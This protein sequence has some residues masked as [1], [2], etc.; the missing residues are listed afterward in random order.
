MDVVKGPLEFS[1]SPPRPDVPP[2]SSTFG[3][4]Q[5]PP[6]R[7]MSH[8]TGSSPVQRSAGS[9]GR[10]ARLDEHFEEKHNLIRGRGGALTPVRPKRRPSLS[11]VLAHSERLNSSTPQASF[12]TPTAAGK[13]LGLPQL[14]RG[15]V[16]VRPPPAG[17]KLARLH[18]SG[19]T[20]RKPIPLPFLF[21]DADEMVEAEQVEQSQA[22]ARHCESQGSDLDPFQGEAR[23]NQASDTGYRIAVFG[24]WLRLPPPSSTAKLAA[25]GESCAGSEQ[26]GTLCRRD[27]QKA[28]PSYEAGPDS[29]GSQCP[30]PMDAHDHASLGRRMVAVHAGVSSAE[31]AMWKPEDQVTGALTR[32]VPNFCGDGQA[33]DCTMRD[34]ADNDV[35]NID[36]TSV[37]DLGQMDTDGS[38]T[39]PELPSSSSDSDDSPVL[40]VN[41][42]RSNGKKTLARQNAEQTVD[43]V[44]E[45]ESIRSKMPLADDTN[46]ALSST[47]RAV[48]SV[49]IPD[50]SFI[51]SSM[52]GTRS[53][54]A[55]HLNRRNNL[56][57]PVPSITITH[58]PLNVCSSYPELP[59]LS[60]AM[61]N[62][63]P[64]LLED[65]D[66]D[67]IRARSPS[68]SKSSLPISQ[69]G[70]LDD[71]QLIDT[72]HP[73]TYF[74]GTNSDIASSGTGALA[75]RS[76]ALTIATDVERTWDEGLAT[77]IRIRNLVDA[78]AF[79]GLTSH[80]DELLSDFLNFKHLRHLEPTCDQLTELLFMASHPQ[81]R[82]HRG[83]FSSVRLRD[84]DLDLV[85]PPS[86]RAEPLALSD[87]LEGLLPVH[88]QRSRKS[89]AEAFLH[90]QSME[91]LFEIL[92]G[93]FTCLLADQRMPH[94][95]PVALALFCR[96]LHKRLN[97][98]IGIYPSF[99][100]GHPCSPQAFSAQSSPNPTERLYPMLP[101]PSAVFVHA[102]QR[103]F[104][105]AL[106]NGYLIR[107]RVSCLA[108]VA[109][110][111]RRAPAGGM[112]RLT[113]EEQK[114]EEL[115]SLARGEI[116]QDEYRLRERRLAARGNPRHAFMSVGGV[117]FLGEL[118]KVGLLPLSMVRDWLRRLLFDTARPEMPS[119]WEL[120]SA[121]ALLI[122]CGGSLE[123]NVQTCHCSA[124][125]LAQ[126]QAQ[127]QAQAQAPS[128]LAP[129][130][131]DGLLSPYRS[132]PLS[133]PTRFTSGG[134]CFGT[135]PSS[136]PAVS[137]RNDGAPVQHWIRSAPPPSPGRKA[138]DFSPLNSQCC[139]TPPRADQLELALS[140]RLSTPLYTPSSPLY[141]PTDLSPTP[142]RSGSGAGGGNKCMCD[143]VRILDRAMERLSLICTYDEHGDGAKEWIEGVLALR[144]QKWHPLATRFAEQETFVH[145][146]RAA[147]AMRAETTNA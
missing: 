103:E 10:R 116:T 29:P 90:L 139:L 101:E 46:L 69:N 39:D 78:A 117:R 131:R 26:R 126:T 63:R 122:T 125:A 124:P 51:A 71:Q 43:A 41:A 42:Q 65:R 55:L 133:G 98:A 132:E 141:G 110:P 36:G 12:A 142:N 6:P 96:T 89:S 5:T 91:K 56:D 62:F 38:L 11:S 99:Y 53:P 82:S 127:A 61:F 17:V 23:A 72:S 30:H 24:G 14:P 95:G 79:P 44:L 48:I 9:V 27:Q 34:V 74:H 145:R 87:S 57:F 119:I 123:D 58:A 16:E 140:A 66:D 143:G 114:I 35:C 118:Y 32:V 60:R 115:Q 120:E 108:A 40:S 18:A 92:V 68:L 86:L 47:S 135:K 83:S 13:T 129:P 52:R 113:R 33:N 21:A 100:V 8:R 134:E 67:N 121:C 138:T 147:Q 3:L 128:D 137:A 19:R 70:R 50:D 102:L 15:K 104:N 136:K 75:R 97:W 144:K 59:L 111:R 7:K 146:P 4:P 31:G 94:Q 25:I 77:L 37:Q 112:A 20:A 84:I 93:G 76:I 28:S 49:S 106:Q 88:E 45:F 80:I 73:A 130:S 81:H 109:G 85:S 105:G 107:D 64:E 22:R 54:G 1:S 2:I